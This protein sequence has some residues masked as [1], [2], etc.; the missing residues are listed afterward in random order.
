[1]RD[2]FIFGT[3]CAVGMVVA[4]VAMLTGIL[5]GH[6]DYDEPDRP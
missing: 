4:C 2:I 1:M 6:E 5:H 3:G